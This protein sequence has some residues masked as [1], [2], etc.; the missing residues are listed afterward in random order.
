MFLCLEDKIDYEKIPNKEGYIRFIT[1]GTSS[2]EK[3][4]IVEIHEFCEQCNRP[5]GYFNGQADGVVLKV[6]IYEKKVVT[7]DK[8]TFN[9]NNFD[10]TE[11][12][13]NNIEKKCFLKK[14]KPIQMRKTVTVCHFQLVYFLC[15]F[16]H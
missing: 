16:Y 3:I 1:Q 4:T 11:L 14:L 13:K 10:P 15:Q 9:Q 6:L 12:E 2:K 5:Y 7:E 8:L